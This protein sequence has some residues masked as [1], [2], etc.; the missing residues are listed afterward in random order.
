MGMPH[1]DIL[2]L[3]RG[4]FQN[5]LDSIQENVELSANLTDSYRDIL[6]HLGEYVQGEDPTIT[7]R[8]RKNE[9]QF[10]DSKTWNES[11][12]EFQYRIGKSRSDKSQRVLGHVLYSP[13]VSINTDEDTT[14]EYW[15]LVEL[16]RSKFD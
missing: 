16:D 14:I 11:V 1:H 2:H 8:R 15:A 6:K 7:S 9:F 13:P 10:E 3:G 5:A 4:S 12:T